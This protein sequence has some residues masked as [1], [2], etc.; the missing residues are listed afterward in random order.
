MDSG[1]KFRAGFLIGTGKQNR[2]VGCNMLKIRRV[3]NVAI[4]IL[5][6]MLVTLAEVFIT[7]QPSAGAIRDIDANSKKMSID[8]SAMTNDEILSHL[9]RETGWVSRV[10]RQGRT[11]EESAAEFL[12]PK[13]KKQIY[14]RNTARKAKVSEIG[15][16]A[17][18]KNGRRIETN[19][20]KSILDN[21][22]FFSQFK[23]R[24]TLFTS[25]LS[26][27]ASHR[28]YAVNSRLG[29]GWIGVVFLSPSG[30]Q[31]TVVFNRKTGKAFYKDIKILRKDIRLPMMQK[32]IAMT[33]ACASVQ[34]TESAV[35]HLSRTEYAGV[36]T[37]AFAAPSASS[38]SAAVS[39]TGSDGAKERKDMEVS[40]TSGAG[41]MA[42][43]KR[44]TG[45]VSKIERERRKR[46]AELEAEV[47]AGADKEKILQNSFT[48]QARHSG[49]FG[50]GGISVKF[51]PGETPEPARSGA[52]L[53]AKN[54]EKNN[55]RLVR[56]IVANRK[57]FSRVKGQDNIPALHPEGGYRI[58]NI[59]TQIGEGY[60]GIVFLSPSG[61]QEA[62]VFNTENG[63]PLFK[64]VKTPEKEIYAAM[65]KN[66]LSLADAY[67][68]ARNIAFIRSRNTVLQD[69][70]IPVAIDTAALA[71]EGG[72]SEQDEDERQDEYDPEYAYAGQNVEDSF[73]EYDEEGQSV[74][75][76][77]AQST[78]SDNTGADGNIL[79]QFK[80]ETGWVSRI[81][82]QKRERQAE[83]TAAAGESS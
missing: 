42:E 31:E 76:T 13:R 39:V 52:P 25:T 48:A 18:R 71:R 1:K 47:N 8:V 63:R 44:K 80:R 32:S 2:K 68:L 70:T 74:S 69:E 4:N 26:D 46:M 33:D 67:F 34:D 64:N 6:I 78:D 79:E 27:Y 60:I 53:V 66:S 62:M 12:L 37:N 7:C 11:E 81:V 73:S 29:E 65:L 51:T 55:E 14:V 35:R 45:W 24:R 43:F 22:D 21:W 59:N 50:S 10:A 40:L 61:T 57:F 56:D 38:S 16:P 77:A 54:T 3:I 30:M 72:N 58:Y 20:M 83:E 15:Y 23:N 49:D 82:R 19:L 17:E 36:N 9:R 5:P 28:I 41:I 75:F